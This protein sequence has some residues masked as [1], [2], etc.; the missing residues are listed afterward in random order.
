MQTGWEALYKEESK[1]DDIVCMDEFYYS[2]PPLSDSEGDS[3]SSGISSTSSLNVANTW[4]AIDDDSENYSQKLPSGYVPLQPPKA[5][6]PK[7]AEP[8]KGIF[9]NFF[10]KRDLNRAKFERYARNFSFAIESFEKT[11]QRNQKETKKIRKLMHKDK[12]KWRR[13][14][15]TSMEDMARNYYENWLLLTSCRIQVA[16]RQ[17]EVAQEWFNDAQQV[18]DGRNMN[19]FS[20]RWFGPDGGF[21]P[22]DSIPLAED[23]LEVVQT[24]EMMEQVVSD[25]K[26]HYKAKKKQAVRKSSREDR[27]VTLLQILELAYQS[28]QIARHS[29][30]EHEFHWHPT[31]LQKSDQQ[32][33]QVLFNSFIL[34]QRHSPGIL[35]HR[36]YS[37]IEKDAE[38]SPQ[39]ITD[40]IEYL[41][42]HLAGFHMLDRKYN[43][44][45]SLFLERLIFPR[46]IINKELPLYTHQITSEDTEK[47]SKFAQNCN[48][49]SKLSQ[50]QLDV[51]PN[52]QKRED[53]SEEKP[54]Q[55]A[56]DA[57]RNIRKK[58][59]TDVL[60]SI[61]D[62][63]RKIN[64]CAQ[65]YATEDARVTADDLF[66]MVVFVVANSDLDD[67]NQRLGFLERYVKEKVKIFGEPA[68]CLTLLQAAVAY[69]CERSPADFFEKKSASEVDADEPTCATEV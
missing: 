29:S 59:P 7:P 45:V 56:I 3:I 43:S 38:V 67:I 5:G 49:M 6:Q 64:Q 65:D 13:F 1:N 16:A 10:R 46:I 28:R 58:V 2:I 27:R 52:F 42:A 36:W 32:I 54:F 9:S 4:R 8:R 47:D 41:V 23:A 53:D 14:A 11:I 22:P 15:H 31:D 21:I 44:V 40:F 34:D 62:C 51:N 20:H 60:F 12:V 68:I 39:S 30:K 19:S 61:L 55:I 35:I 26:E 33:A 17:M 66:P 48:W 69:I 18:L 24:C 50:T 57:I 63:V 25:L 37:T